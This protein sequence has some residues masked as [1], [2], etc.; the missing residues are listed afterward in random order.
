MDKPVPNQLCLC[1]LT[2]FRDNV[3]P[4]MKKA[5]KYKMNV[6]N[7]GGGADWV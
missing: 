1:G 7:K 4:A 5:A 6:E 2:S 3:C